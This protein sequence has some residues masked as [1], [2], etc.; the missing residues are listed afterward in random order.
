MG[1]GDPCLPYQGT[2]DCSLVIIH[3][4]S[5]PARKPMSSTH[6][7]RGAEKYDSYMGR[8]SRRL[9]PMFLDFAGLADGENVLEVGCGT[10]S[11]TFM[12]SNRA[13]LS[14]VEAVDY[15]ADFVAAARR[16][17]SDP[18]IN[19]SEGDAC[20]L[21]F[22]DR[23]F[24][25]ALSML[26]LHFVA[27]PER[28]IA[29]MRRVVREGGIVAATVWDIFG[30]MPAL[31]MFW[32]SAATLDPVANHHRNSS[33]MRPMTQPSELCCAFLK[34]GFLD[35]RETELVIRMDFTNFDDYWIPLMTGQGK[36]SE[37][38]SALSKPNRQRMEDAVRASYLCD[39]P[40]GPRSFV[41]VARAVRGTVPKR[42]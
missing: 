29:E 35:V 9:A 23:A 10:G 12:L 26:V 28:A 38:M 41:G 34:A 14:Y 39:R 3:F 7:S 4:L 25:R 16:R 31:R 40:D 19:I 18:R 30:G 17:N 42:D 20:S 2:L 22:A 6:I 27:D 5:V 24:D 15:D 32:D 37:F 33:L 13:E 36:H 11:L 21:Q 1:E 8:W